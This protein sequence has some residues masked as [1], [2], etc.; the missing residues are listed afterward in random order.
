MFLESQIN[1]IVKEAIKH[2]AELPWIEFKTNN[3]NPQMIGENISALSN[4]ATLYSQQNALMI[5]GIEDETH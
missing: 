5:W 3:T 2:S 4:A 1:S